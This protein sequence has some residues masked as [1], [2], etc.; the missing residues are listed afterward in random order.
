MPAGSQLPQPA[1]PAQPVLPNFPADP[2]GLPC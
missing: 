2:N 1:G